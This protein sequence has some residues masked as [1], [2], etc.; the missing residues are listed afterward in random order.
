MLPRLLPHNG[1]VLISGGSVIHRQD[2]A[3]VSA[4]HHLSLTLDDPNKLKLC[5]RL[6]IV[7]GHGEIGDLDNVRVFD[8]LDW[9]PTAETG[10]GGEGKEEKGEENKAVKSHGW[11]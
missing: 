10:G 3:V 2:E 11:C 8:V 1:L 7:F 6:L 5:P 4:G 9:G